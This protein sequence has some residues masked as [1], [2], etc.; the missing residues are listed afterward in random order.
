MSERS[1]HIVVM[2]LSTPFARVLSAALVLG[3]IAITACAGSNSDAQQQAQ[4]ATTPPTPPQIVTPPVAPDSFRVVFETSRGPFTVQIHRRWAP[5]GADRFYEL[6]QAHFY[7]ENRFFRV[8]PHFVAQFGINDKPKVNDVWDA[9]RIHD[10]SVAQPNARGSIVFATEG[11]DTRTHQLFINLVDNANL[12]GMGF[13]PMGRVV[14]GMEAVD[15]LYSGYGEQPDQGYIQTL[16][17]Q[18]LTRMFPKLDYI[19][20]ARVTTTP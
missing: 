17:N 7:D 19:K 9:K 6:V 16:G 15:S 11:P 14:Q 12:D 8:V 4:S 18:Y 3:S 10:D 5:L 13:A 2:K 1:F 20:T